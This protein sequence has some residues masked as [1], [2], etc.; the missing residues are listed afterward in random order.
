MPRSRPFAARRVAGRAARAPRRRRSMPRLG[1]SVGGALFGVVWM[2]FALLFLALAIWNTVDIGQLRASGVR[3]TGT[4][5][6]TWTETSTS[7]S[8][9]ANGF[10]TTT[11]TT[12]HYTQVRYIDR[13]G[14]THVET[15]SGSHRPPSAVAVVYHADDP[16]SVRAAGEVSGFS[17]GLA[18]FLVLFS[19]GFVLFGLT[20][21]LRW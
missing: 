17:F 20:F 3:T 19:A 2:G 10:T 6:R 15:V 18:I 5:L 9:D 13:D 4:A 21:F 16:G 8:T 14:V 12:S 11:T 1:W 7:T